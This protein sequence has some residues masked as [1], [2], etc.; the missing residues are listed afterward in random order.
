VKAGLRNTSA[1]PRLVSG[2]LRFR[3]LV[4]LNSVFRPTRDGR[5]SEQVREVN[6]HGVFPRNTQDSWRLHVSKYGLQPPAPADVHEMFGIFGI[7][8]YLCG[9]SRGFVG[10][11]RFHQFGI[12]GI[13][14]IFENVRSRVVVNKQTK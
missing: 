8:E 9:N 1:A 6:T 10:I 4:V 5:R 13:F 12:F 7:F 11:P 2:R 14:E 3:T